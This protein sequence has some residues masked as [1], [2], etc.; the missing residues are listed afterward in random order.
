MAHDTA[1]IEIALGTRPAG[2]SLSLWLYD[3]LRR[4][5]LSGRL[6][7]GG[8]LPASRDFARQI[9]VSRG[10]AVGVFERLHSDGYLCSRVG[11]GTWVNE[12]LPTEWSRPKPAPRRVRMVPPPLGGLSFHPPPRPF[13]MCEPIGEFPVKIWARVA[14]RRLRRLTPAMLSGGDLRGCQPL[15]EAIAGYLGSSRG[16]NCA[17]EQVA[18]VSGVQQ[19]LDILARLL[20]KS[21]DAIWMEDP[22]YFGA[23]MAFE[24]ANAKIVPVPVDRD[25]LVVAEGQRRA[26][27]AKA[28]YVTPAHQFPLGMSMSL[29]RRLE[30]LAWARAH[31]AFVIEDD[32]DSEFRFERHP[33]GALQGIDRAGNVVFV[34]SF[35]KFLFPSL[36]VGYVVLP[37]ALMDPFL[38]L[39]Y[40]A[41]LRSPAI[42]QMILC[43]FITEG[44]LGR[45]LRRSREV[46][47]ERLTVLL[48]EGRKR[49]DG[50]LEI[51]EV[52]AGLFTAGLLRNRMSS[53]RSEEAAARASVDVMGLHRFTFRRKDVR[54]VLLGFA[55]FDARQIRAGVER[56]AG[57]LA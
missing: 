41:D 9:G 14:S 49:L 43:D 51:S 55:A 30:L 34:G 44:H 15:R 38:A 1:S 40:S 8:R 33:L 31:R 48:D 5:I 6:R 32:Y 54:G 11:S 42:E 2:T 3:E 22:G 45:H 19:A 21:G 17:P 47:G 39:R 23:T 13:R 29:Q 27:H 25:G 28:C 4:A 57:A 7:P 16:V 20:L 37:P 12:S 50:L 46:Y 53:R 36:R 26:R 56:L 35:N 18:I 10:I 24:R 52:R